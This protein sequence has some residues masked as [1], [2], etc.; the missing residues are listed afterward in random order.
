M[1]FCA[2]DTSR[3]KVGGSSADE[4][5]CED[6]ALDSIKTGTDEEICA[7]D[8]LLYFRSDWLMHRAWRARVQ[9]HILFILFR[10]SAVSRRMCAFVL[11]MGQ[12][13]ARDRQRGG[14][15]LN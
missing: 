4:M 15:E 10:L 14:H 1:P 13:S 3:Q 12:N 6:G 2:T 7:Q 5:R 11:F 8:I 9:I